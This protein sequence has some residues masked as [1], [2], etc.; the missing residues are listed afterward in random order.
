VVAVLREGD[1]AVGVNLADG[2]QVMAGRAVIANVAP[3]A[4]ARLAGPTPEPAYDAALKK[5]SHA[6]GTMMIHLAVES[7]PVWTAGEALQRFAYVHIAPTLD[8]MARAYQQA[9]AGLLPDA[10]VIVVGQPTA[11]DPTRAP[12]GTHVLWLQVRMA[13]GTIAGDAAGAI[14]A[15]G[16]TEAA[17]PFADRALEIVERYAPGLGAKVLGRRIVTPAELEAD[18]PNLVGGDQFA[19]SHHLSQHFL[20][21]P[22]RGRAD[23]ATPVAGLYHTGASVWPGAGTGVGP[24]YL[25]GQK[26][27]GG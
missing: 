25:L 17:E 20:F 9:K 18:N 21:R 11:I 8:G 19:G 27:A 7:L 15:T 12:E 23:G 24:G 1:R 16:W 26:L 6:P 14:A 22:V 4:L 13:P 3:G 5:F 2:R 10:P